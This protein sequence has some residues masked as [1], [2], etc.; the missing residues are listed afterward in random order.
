MYNSYMYYTL[1]VQ[2][3]GHPIRG[4]NFVVVLLFFFNLFI[5][6][7][8]LQNPVVILFPDRVVFMSIVTMTYLF[9]RIICHSHWPKAAPNQIG[10][11]G[12]IWVNVSHNSIVS[13]GIEKNITGFCK[14]S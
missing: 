2:P 14:V 4:L 9:N 7:Q 10:V 8:D 1:G 12:V 3:F 11:L 5:G 13:Q 6:S